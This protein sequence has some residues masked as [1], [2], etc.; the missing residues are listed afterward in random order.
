MALL[1]LLQKDQ[2][3]VKTASSKNAVKR[4]HENDDTEL[5]KK[6]RR[7]TAI[8]STVKVERICPFIYS[9]CIHTRHTLIMRSTFF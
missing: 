9:N 4:K 8:S 7:K 3:I 1:H 6:H 5:T 2:L